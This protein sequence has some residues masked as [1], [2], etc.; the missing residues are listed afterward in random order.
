MQRNAIILG[1]ITAIVM[2]SLAPIAAADDVSDLK[3]QIE[4]LNARLEKMETQK[5]GQIEKEELAK[6]MKEIL[7]DAQAAPALP[8][9]M[10]D[11]KFY[12]LF[13][14]RAESLTF[15][16]KR[17]GGDAGTPQ[18][19]ERKNRNRIRTLLLFGLV[20]T[21]WDK[22]MEVGFQLSTGDAAPN[23]AHQT[24]TGDFSKKPIWIHLM[25]A[26]YKPNWAKGLEIGGGKVRNPIKTLTAMTWS[27]A[28]NPEGIY[29]DYVA[30]FF[31]D[32][33]PYGQIGFWMV[34]EEG[35]RDAVGM[36]AG[37]T[38]RDTVM[39]SYSLGFDWKI[40]NA[41]DWFFGATY[42]KYYNADAST[43]G[44]LGR[45]GADGQ[46]ASGPGGQTPAQNQAAATEAYA[47]ADFGI[48]EL[49]TKVGWKMDFLPVP[50]QKWEA[51]FSYVRNCKDD[52]STLKNPS[53]VPGT[54]S[55]LGGLGAD[56]HFKS[57][58][59]AYGVGIKVGENRK[60]GDFSIAY[61][62]YYMEY[63]SIV[64]G[65]ISP[66]LLYPN[67]QAHVIHAIYNID[68]FLTLG[69]LVAIENPIHTNDNP[70][71]AAANNTTPAATPAQVIFPHSQDTTAVF[72]IELTWKF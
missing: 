42:Y 32:F 70:A 13:R 16:G 21:W 23:A 26:K 11:L 52:Y 57:D 5:S 10:K 28:L 47:S 68:D 6:M 56:R 3:A 29:V 22:Q 48:L 71:N 7:D 20:K 53:W 51:W 12:G 69:G 25:Y 63:G 41:V 45:Y 34:N 44:W 35:T 59:N 17:G 60:K 8:A 64:P 54:A 65:F 38:L 72:R 55:T 66:D 18:I 1:C 15:Q 50:F 14:L 24:L 36:A 49:T 67:N 40:A 62:Y 33:K 43:G 46:W 30:P 61:S 2:L 9:W 27:D 58:P 37:S 19:G 39:M 4:R 31:G